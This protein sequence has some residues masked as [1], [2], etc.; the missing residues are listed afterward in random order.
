MPALRT[1]IRDKMI[2]LVAALDGFTTDLVSAHKLDKVEKGNEASVYLQGV[3]SEPA[4]SRGIRKRDQRVNVSLFLEDATDAE[5][6]ASTLL[7]DLEA[8]VETA[9]RAAGFGTIAGVYLESANV[10]H[11]PTSKGKRCDLHATFLFE[12]TEAIA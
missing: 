11:D 8:A 3:E 5:A 10:A 7:N 2:E 1:E 4:A 6:K 12:Y 9:R